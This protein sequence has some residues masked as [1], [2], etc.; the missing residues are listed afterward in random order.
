MSRM[1]KGA[2]AVVGALALTAPLLNPA[3]VAVTPIG[4]VAMMY[5]SGVTYGDA[6]PVNFDPLSAGHP[7]R[8][9][10]GN[11]L[12]EFD[13]LQSDGAAANAKFYGLAARS[14][15]TYTFEGD[16]WNVD[17][18]PDIRFAE[19]TWNNTWHA[20]AA[21]VYL[22]D[23]MV[24]DTGGNL[25][26]YGPADDGLGYYAGIVWNKVGIAG[27]SASAREALAESY[28][29]VG[30]SRTFEGNTF[31]Q[32][33]NFGISEF[34]LPEEVVHA[35]GITL[36]D[37]TKDV[38]TMAGLSASYTGP[39]SA[40]TQ[41]LVTGLDPLAYTS[42]PGEGNTDGYDLDAIRVYKYD[43]WRTGDSA[44]VAGTRILSK[45]SWFMFAQV[46]LSL[47]GEQ[48]FDIQAGNPADGINVIG[49]F[50]VTCI[51]DGT[52]VV[53]YDVD[54]TVEMNGYVYDIVVMG[55]GELAIK[56]GTFATAKPGLEDNQDFGVPFTDADGMF[57]MFAHI[58]VQYQ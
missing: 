45:G 31:S 10:P 18:V 46:D 9:V 43:P 1:K 24:R 27:L 23:A 7:L 25:V 5:A 34:N 37:I 49:E 4:D 39:A 58:T 16:Y 33:G 15:T 52:Y 54:K 20:E 57:K 19:V 14:S 21:L 42:G 30:V 28:L 2:L 3:A 44:T 12:G 11:A 40:G 6:T 8:L 35:N 22:T 26:S 13:A 41:L 17:D 56:D 55:P 48:R 53:T 32:L 36:V 29:P 50:I 51:G 38:Y 47:C